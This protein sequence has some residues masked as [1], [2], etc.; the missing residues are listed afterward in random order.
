MAATTT[1]TLNTNKM[2]LYFAV[3]VAVITS[4]C[5]SVEAIRCHQCNSHNR[6]DCI[7]LRLSTPGN[8]LDDQFLKECEGP[9]NATAFCRKTVLKIEVTGEQRI[10]RECGWKRDRAQQEGIS[11]FSA[12]NEGYLQTICACDT[13]GCNGSPSLMGGNSKWTVLSVTALS[14]AVAAVL[15]RN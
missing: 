1:S 11:C 13:D 7:T 5:L 15:R 8:A 14:V 12:D 2:M 9:H 10:I 4:Q 3:I 6:E